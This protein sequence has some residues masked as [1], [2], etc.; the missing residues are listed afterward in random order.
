MSK[1]IVIMKLQYYKQSA[2]IYLHLKERQFKHLKDVNVTLYFLYTEMYFAA[3]KIFFLIFYK[4]RMCGVFL[5]LSFTF[6]TKLLEA[7]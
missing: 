5:Y 2:D 1:K 6:I 4:Q 7:S 3:N